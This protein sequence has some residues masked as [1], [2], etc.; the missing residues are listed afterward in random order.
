[1]RLLL[2]LIALA[3]AV[4]ASGQAPAEPGAAVLD[5]I[6]RQFPEEQAAISSAVSGRIGDA[7]RPAAH[8]AIDAFL[9]RHA[10]A[11]G[12]APGPALVAIEA[13]HAAVLKA[14]A[15]KDVA[16]CAVAG[17]RGLF[18]APALPAFAAEGLGDYGVALV[19]AAKAGA[20]PAATAPELPTQDDLKAWLAQV[21]RIAPDVPVGRMLADKAVRQSASAD[22]LC[23]GAVAMHEAVG[24][25]PA[26][27]AGRIARVLVAATVARA[28]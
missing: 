7:A 15:R 10:A 21:E 27:Q 16:L 4:P 25:L 1:M 6:R 5:A 22:H 9:G 28:N 26:A 2:T 12:A 23:R 11:I 19:E 18:S 20:T 13:R 8:A 3:I 14:V 24:A 17:D